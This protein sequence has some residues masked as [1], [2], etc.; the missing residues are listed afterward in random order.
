MQNYDNFTKILVCVLQSHTNFA[1]ILISCFA[2]FF[3][4]T[5]SVPEFSTAS[6]CYIIAGLGIRSLLLCSKLLI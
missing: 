3:A 1:K 2:E 6:I 4:V 5:Y